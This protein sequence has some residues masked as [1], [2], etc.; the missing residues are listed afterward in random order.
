MSTADL[1]KPSIL[2]CLSREEFKLC[3]ALAFIESQ[4]R[5]DYGGALGLDRYA[6]PGSEPRADSWDEEIRR[7]IR[8]LTFEHGFA[9]EGIVARENGSL[10]CRVV[11]EGNMVYHLML[12]QGQLPS[13][14]D[15][16][17]CAIRWGEQYPSLP[18]DTLRA[19]EADVI[20]SLASVPA[21]PPEVQAS[22][23]ELDAAALDAIGAV[24]GPR[25]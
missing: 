5:N 8:L 14:L 21:L 1:A 20:E 15:A 4:G 19:V 23:E 24:R 11:E 16:V 13:V 17:R 2:L 6:T 7:A 10:S 9:F 12:Q 18:L 3:F 25:G 22:L